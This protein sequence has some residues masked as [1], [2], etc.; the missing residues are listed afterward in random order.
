MRDP[1]SSQLTGCGPEDTKPRR[2]DLISPVCGGKA[3]PVEDFRRDVQMIRVPAWSSV[4]ACLLLLPTGRINFPTPDDRR[5]TEVRGAPFDPP[6]LRGYRWPTTERGAVT[7]SFGDF[8]TTHFHLGIDLSTNDV[9]GWP[10]VAAREGYVSRISIHPTGYGR[11]LF[12]RHPD[13]NT[14]VYAHLSRFAPALQQRAEEEQ[15]RLEQYPVDIRCEPGDYP[16]QAGD[17]IGW[18]GDSG[19]GDAHLHFEVRDQAMDGINPAFAE[20]LG[21]EDSLPPSVIAVAFIPAA[22]NSFV[23]GD[24]EPLLR[25]PTRLREGVHLVKEPVRFTG[26]LG[27][28]VDARDHSNATRHT[29]GVFR[30]RLFF[31][32]EQRTEVRF[33]RV[34]AHEGQLIGVAYDFP[35]YRARKGRFLRLFTPRPN[36]LPTHHTAENGTGTFDASEFASGPD[37]ATVLVEDFDGNATIVRVVL[38][39]R[40]VVERKSRSGDGSR[41]EAIGMELLPDDQKITV[42]LRAHLT[43]RDSI[44]V[45]LTE[46]DRTRVLPLRS[47]RPGMYL[48]SFRPDE[49]Y[50]G[51]RKVT[52]RGGVR[53]R[54]VTREESLHIIPLI[55]GKTGAARFAGGNIRLSWGTDAVFHPV[56]LSAA[57][58]AED[59]LLSL[60]PHD[61]ALREG[62]DIEVL[63]TGDTTLARLYGRRTRGWSLLSN[64]PADAEGILRATLRRWTGD[65]SVRSDRTPPSVSRFRLYTS[66]GGDVTISFRFR[67]NLSG[68]EYESLKMYIDGV[69]V[70]PE[71]DGEHRTATYRT[72]T[73]LPRGSH[74]LTLQLAD[75]LGNMTTITRPFVVR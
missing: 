42:R 1:T 60:R 74:R 59:S 19:T 53:G 41:A 22:E 18:T 34:P 17:L 52:A 3:L 23:E 14:T 71:I 33:D 64:R 50:Q 51:I 38:D 7:S 40:D 63:L 32:G 46:G 31:R 28:A 27:I 47:Y 5:A 70:I 65:I 36:T 39:G 44:H 62:L 29:R 8:R 45:S 9:T 25:T 54:P 69:S 61:V 2:E 58:L 20:G 66:S 35:L 4:L 26:K 24:I 67:D 6:I 30:S 55:P 21:A 75:K 37:T 43:E 11:L 72:S 49:S 56:F 73:P 15:R 16:V 12:I 48:A 13:G 10:V 68:V 57:V